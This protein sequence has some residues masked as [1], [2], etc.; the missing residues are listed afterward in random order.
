[1]KIRTI[2]SAL[3]G[4]ILF[5]ACS[6]GGAGSAG[7]EGTLIPVPDP[8]TPEHPASVATRADLEAVRNDLSGFIILTADIDLGGQ[9]WIPIGSAGTPFTGTFDGDGYAI[10]NITISGNNQYQG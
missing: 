10:N 8:S 6:A 3:A 9:E 7:D 4:V 1:M 5:V 2:L